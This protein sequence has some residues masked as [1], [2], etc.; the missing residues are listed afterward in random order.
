MSAK[1]SKKDGNPVTVPNKSK[2]LIHTTD[3]QIA[4]NCHMTTQI[5]SRD[6]ITVYTNWNLFYGREYFDGL[7]EAG[8]GNEYHR[9]LTFQFLSGDE[10]GIYLEILAKV[11]DVDGLTFANYINLYQ[12][13]D[14]HLITDILPS[15]KSQIINIKFNLSIYVFN[16]EYKILTIAELAKMYIDYSLQYT[17]E[18][19][20]PAEDET[21]WDQVF[22]QLNILPDDVW[23]LVRQLHPNILE[24]HLIKCKPKQSV[25]SLNICVTNNFHDPRILFFIKHCLSSWATR[26]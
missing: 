20:P 10:V 14:Y 15:L 6:N 23:H 13:F 12:Q 4:K 21:F 17:H 16:R 26:R 11:R 1:R 24:K 3:S 18:E 9:P 8:I 22:T 25:K 7:I 19:H 2:L 5:L